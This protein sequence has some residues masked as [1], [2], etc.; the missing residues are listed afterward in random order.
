MWLRVR[1][2]LE[3]DFAVASPMILLLRPRS[4]A[5]QWVA[6]D[7]YSVWPVAPIEEYTDMYGNPCQRLLAPA[8]RFQLEVSSDV[9]VPSGA[10][11]KPGGAFVPVQLLPAETLMYLAPSR[12]C[13]S[14]K[15]GIL[16][17]GI[18][19][20]SRPGYDQVQA[21]SN[22]IRSR[23][24]YRA[25]SDPAPVSAVEALN[26]GDGV[27]RDFAH[28]GIALCRSLTIPA[29]MIVG[30]LHRLEPMDLHAWFEAFVGGRWYAFDPTQAT[31][32][33]GRVRLA[34]GRDAAD[35]PVFTQ[36]GPPVIPSRMDITVEEIPS[37][38]M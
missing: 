30:Y 2:S 29:R 13:E 20:S 7:R 31:M 34:N 3:M 27:C 16:A 25:D 19:G 4:D 23:L 15:L 33:G 35:V 6:R 22:W 12:Y 8:G 1:C 17:S 14:D 38:T 10:D 9:R 11:R 18:V 26:R 32:R 28:L 24:A 37:R 21:L 36:F 5:R